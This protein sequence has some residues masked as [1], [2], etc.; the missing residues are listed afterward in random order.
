MENIMYKNAQKKN[1]IQN[2]KLKLKFKIQKIASNFI[3]SFF[4]L[5]ADLRIQY[6]SI[7]ECSISN[8]YPVRFI[9]SITILR[10]IYEIR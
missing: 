10:E 5:S 4:P 3:S 9:P 1:Q 7:Y 6:Q 8:N 2:W